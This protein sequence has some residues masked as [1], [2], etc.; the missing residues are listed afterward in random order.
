MSQF[1]AKT[2]TAFEGLADAPRSRYALPTRRAWQGGC[3]LLIDCESSF[4]E[5]KFVHGRMARGGHGLPKVSPRLAM[6]YRFM[7]CGRATPETAVRLF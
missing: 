7:T 5:I 3:R 4:D 1:S 2:W 6:P